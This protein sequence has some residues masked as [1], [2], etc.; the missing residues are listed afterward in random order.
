[1]AA[2]NRGY[3]PTRDNDLVPWGDNF[4]QRVSANKTLFGIPEPVV[5]ELSLS[6]EN[7]VGAVGEIFKYGRTQAR[8]RRG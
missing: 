8:T 1:M 3:L 4:V 2:N 5:T 6:F 7:F